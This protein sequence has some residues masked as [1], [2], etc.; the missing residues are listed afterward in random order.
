[1]LMATA[2]MAAIL[3]VSRADAQV[4]YNRDGFITFEDF[5]SFVDDF[6]VGKPRSDLNSDLAIDFVDFDTFMQARGQVNFWFYWMVPSREPG[7]NDMDTETDVGDAPVRRD[8]FIFFAQQFSKALWLIDGK[9]TTSTADD[10]TVDEGAHVMFR[11]PGYSTTPTYNNWRTNHTSWMTAHAANV[12]AVVPTIVENPNFSGLISLDFERI[13]PSWD[14]LV[15]LSQRP[16]DN[17]VTPT[18][19]E[20][21]VDKWKLMIAAINAAAWNTEFIGLIGYIPPA[22]KAKWS[23][24]T[25]TEQTA[26]SKKAYNVFT[27]DYFVQ[28]VNNARAVRPNAKYGYYNLPMA[29]YGQLFPG[30]QA[31]NND[32]SSLWS[33]VDVLYPSL[34]VKYYST[35]DSITDPPLCPKSVNTPQENDEWYQD[36][37]A[38]ECNRI[39]STWG[40]PFGKPNQKIMPFVWWRYHDQAVKCIDPEPCKFPLRFLN[41]TNLCQAIRQPWLY[42][43][44]ALILWG[45]L[46]YDSCNQKYAE[47]PLVLGPEIRNRWGPIMKEILP[48]PSTSSRGI[49]YG[50]W[51]D[52]PPWRGN[53]GFD[54]SRSTQ[55]ASP[56]ALEDR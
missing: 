15:R 9:G 20:I 34:Y 41:N 17:L 37:L 50:P 48:V 42:G 40:I 27:I 6:V 24:L 44:D 43:A 38:E 35:A 19:L 7:R 32:L 12:R 29:W 45:F 54:E 11:D 51:N 28:T 18:D 2:V 1:M 56:V 23:D 4:D 36:V 10:T 39:R 53:E 13:Y 30:Q 3:P 49:D 55:T 22:G 47:D 16:A 21:Q 46:G 52:S 25:S 8:C 14:G 33:S 26:L 31:D 5:D